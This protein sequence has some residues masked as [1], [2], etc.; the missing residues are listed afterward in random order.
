M[1][2]ILS[3]RDADGDS[4]WDRYAKH[5]EAWEEKKNSRKKAKREDLVRAQRA[6]ELKAMKAKKPSKKRKSRLPIKM[7]KLPKIKKRK[8][9]LP[10]RTKKQLMVDLISDS[11]DDRRADCISVISSTASATAATKAAH[12]SLVSALLEHKAQG[13]HPDPDIF[14]TEHVTSLFTNKK[15]G[16]RAMQ[17]KY[18]DLFKGKV[19][20][21]S[22]LRNTNTAHFT[23]RMKVKEAYEDDGVP[24][25]LAYYRTIPK[26]VKR[27]SHMQTNA[28]GKVVQQTDELEIQAIE[29]T[30]LSQL[31]GA[32]LRRMNGM[33]RCA[34]PHSCGFVASHLRGAFLEYNYYLYTLA[35]ELE[36]DSIMDWDQA[37]FEQR[38]SGEW[39]FDQP[40]PSTSDIKAH[41]RVKMA[42]DQSCIFCGKRKCHDPTPTVSK[43][44]N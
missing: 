39:D 25:D 35:H 13:L 4:A 41:W 17:L 8:Q 24:W 18:P 15:H 32:I 43:N 11:E 10:K 22:L 29:F 30:T 31:I 42:A 38:K 2:S 44:A 23:S 34:V 12:S 16:P 36:Y 6:A 28:D 7:E 26:G 27:K 19:H 21:S 37:L 1:G 14:K 33:L 3:V 40:V 9:D 20:V 5:A